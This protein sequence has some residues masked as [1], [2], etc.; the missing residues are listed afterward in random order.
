[1]GF[2]CGKWLITTTSCPLLAKPFIKTSDIMKWLFATWGKTPRILAPE[3]Y[4]RRHCNKA[5]M[6]KDRM[7]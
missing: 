3:E 7:K 4:P 5:P 6:K 1:M 2:F